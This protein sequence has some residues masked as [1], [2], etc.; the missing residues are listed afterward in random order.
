MSK[1]MATAKKSSKE[2]K[3]QGKIQAAPKKGKIFAL[4]EDGVPISVTLRARVKGDVLIRLRIV[5]KSYSAEDIAELLNKGNE[6]WEGIQAARYHR[7]MK[8]ARIIAEIEF[9]DENI[10]WERYREG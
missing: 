6:S 8:G 9:A 4:D 2:V 7:V 10:H 1:D 5:D 3:T